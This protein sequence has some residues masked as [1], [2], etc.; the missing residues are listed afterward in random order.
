MVLPHPLFMFTENIMTKLIESKKEYRLEIVRGDGDL[1]YVNVS[2]VYR[3][4]LADKLKP[5]NDDELDTSIIDNINSSTSREVAKRVVDLIHTNDISTRVT[6]VVV[7]DE[8]LFDRLHKWVVGLHKMRL[9]HI[10]F[11][12]S[13]L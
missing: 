6:T 9:Q 11:Q 2:N 5:W 3:A 7:D 4:I 12:V 13:Q 8:E 10:K 1:V